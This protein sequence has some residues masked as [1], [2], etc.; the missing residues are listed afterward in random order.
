MK[1]I[2]ERKMQK[3][4]KSKERKKGE[5]EARGAKWFC[6]AFKLDF[7]QLLGKA[8]LVFKLN[9]EMNESWIMNYFKI[10]TIAWVI[11]CCGRV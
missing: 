7:L 1:T 10:K 4:T 2:D 5:R 8:S 9:L 3:A 11:A 6:C